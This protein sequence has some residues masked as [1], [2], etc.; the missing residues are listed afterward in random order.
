MGIARVVGA[1]VAAV[2]A[3]A[4]AASAAAAPGSLEFGK[5]EKVATLG[6]GVFSNPGCTTPG[7]RNNYVWH[8]LVEPATIKVSKAKSTYY[9]QVSARA[10]AGGSFGIS[11][12]GASGA[13]GSVTARRLEGVILSLKE[14][15][16]G[17]GGPCTSQ[18][19][20]L[21]S[22]RS[23]SL[24]GAP[25]V[26]QRNGIEEGNLDGVELRGEPFLEPATCGSSTVEVR[27]GAIATFPTNLMR[28]KFYV[29]FRAEFL[30][31]GA[32]QIPE[33]FA[34]GPAVLLE[35][36]LSGGPFVHSVLRFESVFT[37]TPKIELR[38]CE[39]DVC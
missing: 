10:G 20:R 8:P 31:E 13:G 17:S 11:C 28:S 7:K 19:Q 15:S 35:S 18:G 38:Q 16:G 14:C 23:G 32:K 39:A 30:S 12:Q 29:E 34:E 26:I 24:E 25:G 1:L 36:S 5:C 21:R 33:A 9:F 37:A 4:L 27:G 6:T 22:V 3:L 2:G